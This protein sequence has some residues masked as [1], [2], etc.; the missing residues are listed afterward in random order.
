[1]VAIPLAVCLTR[2]ITLKDSRAPPPEFKLVGAGV[3]PSPC[4][5]CTTFPSGGA[6]SLLKAKPVGAYVIGTY[7]PSLLITLI[8]LRVGYPEYGNPVL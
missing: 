3:G 5:F 7:G 4:S 2:S 8:G 1:M 6:E